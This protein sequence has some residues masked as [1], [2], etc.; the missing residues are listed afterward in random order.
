MF[1]LEEDS[2]TNHTVLSE[3]DRAQ[4]NAQPPHYRDDEGT[5]S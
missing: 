3:A 2:C 4:G 5:L 1:L